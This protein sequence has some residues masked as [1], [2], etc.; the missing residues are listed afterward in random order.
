MKNWE[1]VIYNNLNKSYGSYQLRKKYV[2]YLFFA[3]LM[4]LVIVVAPTIIIFYQ[5]QAIDTSIGYFPYIISA[6]LERPVDMDVMSAPPPPSEEQRP[7]E[8]EPAPVVVD[9]VIPKSQNTADREKVKAE[10]DSIKNLVNN[11]KNGN[12]FDVNGDSGV[13]YIY[14]DNMPE[15]PGGDGARQRFITQHLVYP[16]SAQ[17]RNIQGLVLVKFLVTKSGDVSN[18]TVLRSPNPLLSREALRVVSLFPRWFP[19]KR[20][21]KPINVWMQLPINFQKN[22]TKG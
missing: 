7:E 18:I 21:G 13:F 20:G 2:K 10:N 5:S 6:E 14:V 12:G 19:G 11:S 17:Q 3:F 15:F 8:N 9:T 16:D 22:Y 1:E 4:S